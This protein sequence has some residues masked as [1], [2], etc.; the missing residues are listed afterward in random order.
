MKTISFIMFLFLFQQF[1]TAQKVDVYN[2]PVQT[3]RSRDFDAIHY[4]I[5]LNVDLEKKTLTG[6]NQITLSPLND[7]FD[8]C[9]LDAAYL[10]VDSIT[11]S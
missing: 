1:A 9:V 6:E 5:R 8:K 11:D 4:K 10:V 2:R 7:N 3:E